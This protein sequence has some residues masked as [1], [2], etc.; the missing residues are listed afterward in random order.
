[1]IF[2]RGLFALKIMST[3]NQV[4]SAILFAVGYLAAPVLLIWGWLR[5]LKTPNTT[6]P[7]I[8]SLIG[9][10]LATV[11]GLLALSTIAYAQIHRFPYYDP[12]L[13]R[14]FR[15]GAL[16][17]AGGLVFGLA[18]VWRPSSLRWH[19]PASGFAMLTFW[20]VAASGE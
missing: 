1:M 10:V 8:L 14:I 7:S 6:A 19:A 16:L 13:L 18:G 3:L 12:L 5:W 17:S 9:F 15:W 2:R 11:S 20:I 4:T